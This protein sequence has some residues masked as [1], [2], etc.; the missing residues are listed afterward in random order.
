VYQFTTTQAQKV[1]I[2]ATSSDS[3]AVL[4]LRTAPCALATSE[5][6]CADFTSDPDPEVIVRPSLPAGTYFVVLTGYS[7]AQG[8]FGLTLTL[9]APQPPPANDT[10]TAPETV[11]LTNG[12]ATRTVDLTAA[13]ADIDSDLCGSNARGPEVVYSV[14]V[15]ANQRLT[16]TATAATVDPV[17][18]FRSPTCT[19]APSLECSDLGGTGDVET[20]TFLSPAAAT[21][22]VV[23]KAYGAAGPVDVTFAVQ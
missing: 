1:T 13:N 10:C 2:T 23:V 15:G 9:D 12:M 14:A 4:A 11:T 5:L 8:N 19:T 7:A 21:Y 3:D 17:V 22:F 20:A 6:A 16:V 18:F